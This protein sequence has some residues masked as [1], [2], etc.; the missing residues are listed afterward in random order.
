MNIQ[1]KIF[2]ILLS[3]ANLQTA[4]AKRN[5][6]HDP[7]KVFEYVCADD[8]GDFEPSSESSA[9]TTDDDWNSGDDEAGQE[10]S[11][12]DAEARLSG[13]RRLLALKAAHTTPTLDD[14]S[15]KFTI[16]PLIIFF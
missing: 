2:T 12:D 8:D 4:M 16:K 9:A 3:T 6:I 15:L 10:S 13:A 7:E 11:D 1:T 14:R 5:F